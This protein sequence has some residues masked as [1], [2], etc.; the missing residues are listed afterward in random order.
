MQAR[1]LFLYVTLVGFVLLALLLTRARPVSAQRAAT[2]ARTVVSDWFPVTP[3]EAWTYQH[4]SR[5]GGNAGGMANPAGER[6][7]TGETIV[8]ATSVPEGTIVTEQTKVLDHEMLNG[9]S[10]QSDHA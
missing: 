1:R 5:D 8:R 9:W 6:G 7:T 10:P 3:G 4:E 2:S